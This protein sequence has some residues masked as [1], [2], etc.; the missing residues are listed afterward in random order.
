MKTFSATLSFLHGGQ[1][2]GQT[3]VAK[4]KYP[5]FYLFVLNCPQSILIIC[6]PKV[7]LPIMSVT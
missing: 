2:H 5:L 7:I 1:T 3:T 6:R 4:R